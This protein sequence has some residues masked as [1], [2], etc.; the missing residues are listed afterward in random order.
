M[1]SL[2]SAAVPKHVVLP[3]TGQVVGARDVGVGTVVAVR[4]GEVV[5]V[6]GVVVGG[7]S[8]VDE[9]SLTGESFPVPKQ[10]PAEVWAGTMNLDGK[11]L[12]LFFSYTFRRQRSQKCSGGDHSPENVMLQVTLP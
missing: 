9:S 3:E 5:P 10:P 8:E 6:D 12:H 4:A 11:R 1:R 2:M 7:H